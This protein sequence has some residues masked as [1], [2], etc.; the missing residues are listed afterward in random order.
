MKG[1]DPIDLVSGQRHAFTVVAKVSRSEAD[2]LLDA[3]DTE[4]SIKTCVF[5]AVRYADEA[6]VMRETGFF[7]VFDPESE[8]F[9]P[10]QDQ[11]EEY[12]D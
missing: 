8:K 10:S 5:G 7:R 1:I 9:V 11:G 4:S 2:Y 6:N 12:Q 3:T